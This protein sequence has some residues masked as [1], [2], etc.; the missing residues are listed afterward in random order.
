M[1]APNIVSSIVGGATGNHVGQLGLVTSS[2]PAG[3]TWRAMVV[4]GAT[5]ET[6]DYLTGD[7]AARGSRIRRRG[8]HSRKQPMTHAAEVI[9][10]AHPAS[11]PI[12][13]TK[14]GTCW[15]NTID[16]ELDYCQNDL[17]HLNKR[18]KI[19]VACLYY[20][21]IYGGRIADIP[22][23]FR[24]STPLVDAMIAGNSDEASGT[25]SLAT[26]IA[27][28]RWRLPANP[29]NRDASH[30]GRIPGL[31][32]ERSQMTSWFAVP[33]LTGSAV[34]R[35]I[36]N[37]LAGNT[38]WVQGTSRGPSGSSAFPDT[39]SDAQQFVIQ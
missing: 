20:L 19:L 3:Q 12:Q 1:P 15:T 34:L 30:D 8:S 38:I 14:Q 21:E 33:D 17:R 13:I 28:S 31:H 11:P 18:G 27:R 7:V 24:V 39:F 4:Q 16:Y 5:F 32:L 36:P 25:R 26:P 22:V 29:A 2:L 35:N 37:G 23:D 10:A 6:T 9:T